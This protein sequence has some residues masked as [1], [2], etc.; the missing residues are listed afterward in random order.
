[1]SPEVEKN[2]DDDEFE[3]YDPKLFDD[4]VDPL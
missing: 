3:K 4:Y 2:L 1:M